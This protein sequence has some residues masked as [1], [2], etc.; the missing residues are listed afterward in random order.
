MIAGVDI[1]RLSPGRLAVP[2]GTRVTVDAGS[3]VPART[4]IEATV[5]VVRRISVSR[6]ARFRGEASASVVKPQ[7]FETDD[8]RKRHLAGPVASSA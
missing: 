1:T 4:K 8:Q 6:D 7:T 3:I 5:G 2:P